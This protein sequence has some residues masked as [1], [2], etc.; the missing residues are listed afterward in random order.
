MTAKVSMFVGFIGV[1]IPFSEEV[2]PFVCRFPDTEGRK[3]EKQM[4]RGYGLL[5][6]LILCKGEEERDRNNACGE[7]PLLR[8]FHFRFE[9]FSFFMFCRLPAI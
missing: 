8:K 9:L 5:F 3:G 7:V 4:G 1:T 6:C 2:Y